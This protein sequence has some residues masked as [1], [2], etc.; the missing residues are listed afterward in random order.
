MKFTRIVV[1]AAAAA[2]VVP[3]A[4]SA[5]SASPAGRSL[6]K[7]QQAAGRSGP[8][9]YYD[10]RVAHPMVT[11]SG[12][13]AD[14]H[15]TSNMAAAQR[16]MSHDLGLR[17]AYEVN[18]ATGTVRALQ[19][20]DGAL[21][22]ASTVKPV[23]RG[24]AYVRGHVAALGLSSSDLSAFHLADDLVTDRG[25]H[26]IRWTES[27]RGIPAFDNDLRVN[28]D[29]RGQVISVLGSPLH[30]LQLSSTRPGVSAS[31][32]MHALENNVRSQR[33]VAVTSGPRGIRQLTTFS[34]GDFARLVIFGGY[35]A[36]RL[37]WHLTLAASAAATYDAVVD[38]STGQVLYRANL[39]KSDSNAT[40]FKNYPGAIKG[41]V[42]HPVDLSTPTDG[43]PNGYL[44]PGAT[45]LVGPNAHAWSDV[46]DDDTAQPSEEVGPSSGTDFI[47]PFTDFNATATDGGCRARALCSW[48][49]DVNSDGSLQ[50]P[51]SWHTNRKQDAVQAFWY[52]NN[53]HDHLASNP[54]GFTNASGQNF[55]GDDPVLVNADDGAATGDDGGPD[56][57]HLDN[58]N[59]TTMP[60]GTS[61]K[62]QMYL[63]NSAFVPFRDINGG[64]AAV[65]VYHENTHG[66][67]NRLITNDDGTGAV[68]SPEA[69]AMG[70]AWSDWY[71]EDYVTR[72]GLQSDDP[73]HAGD[74]N[75]GEY[76]DA[77][78]GVI[79]TQALDCPVGLQGSSACPGRA[80]GAGGGYTFGD[81]GKIIGFPEVHAD[82]EIWGETLW[83][84]RTALIGATGDE[85]LGS[86]LAERMITD[87]MRL[88]PPEPTYLEERNAILAAIH[89]DFA[90]GLRDFLTNTA[91]TVFRN[92]GMGFYAGAVN[93]SDTTPVEDF[94]G[95]P[96]K[97]GPTGS[98]AG[99]VIDGDTGLPGAGLTV[100]I[101]GFTD[102]NSPAG[103]P[104][105]TT[106]DANGH[107]RIAHVPVGTY[108]DLFVL[109]GA[110]F[111]Q[112]RVRGV[113]VKDH[114]ETTADAQIHR[115][116]A[117]LSGGATATAP[118]ETGADFGCGSD[119]LIDQ[120]E[121]SGYSAF[122]PTS[123]SPDNPHTGA[124]QVTVTL[125]QTVNVTKFLADPGNTCGDGAS[126]TTHDF[127]IETSPNGTTWTT[128]VT[129]SFTEA[130]GHHLNPLSPVA[131]GSNVKYV[132]LTMLNPNDTCDVCSGKDFID[133]S[134]LEV[135]GAQPTS[136][137]TG[138]LDAQPS[139]V[140]RGD[141]V[142]FTAN[143]TDPGSAISSYTW[144]F[145]DGSANRTTT[146][147]TT[148]HVYN[149]LGHHTATVT[150]N[151]F[152][153]NTGQATADVTVDPPASPTVT[154]A[155]SGSHGG[156]PITVTCVSA[157]ELR[158][159]GKVSKHVARKDGL[160]SRFVGSLQAA[161]LQAGQATETLRLN[162]ETVRAMK[163]NHVK[164]LKVKVKARA[165]D[166]NH[167]TATVKQ[168][169]PILL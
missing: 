61:P 146:T 1:G 3:L 84:L 53:F 54:I 4:T 167:H 89:A 93:G 144:D 106:T 64:D 55:N 138:T 137:P 56:G 83:D 117:A 136:P 160:P 155:S 74:I 10:I 20:L 161:L 153:G 65:V 90:G 80:P 50:N 14:V 127:T 116:W 71:A 118:D 129:G 149:V 131:G 31:Q 28:V 108:N 151:A 38:A 147:P 110:G 51:T 115:D 112:A 168:K 25:L 94:S 97:S 75:L 105:S 32:A 128:A 159:S 39:T 77:V 73:N 164:H 48:D 158:A 9:P 91:W 35:G 124:P 165:T 33:P 52:V 68:G 113:S 62:M 72:Q 66:L 133:F 21:T 78:P 2:L 148:S 100:G 121:S 22:G 88:S 19:R 5:A 142:N 36:P 26:T 6:P 163:A 103:T 96:A 81:F 104:L 125:P 58:A 46:N 41:G 63:F 130:D 69:G 140:T 82:G 17:G 122:N 134:E 169:V 34:T 42:Q 44:D 150:A 11:R 47:Y 79:R 37:A 7:P 85:V 67:S 86:N 132:R 27:Y 109:A 157:C 87:G 30:G 24:W 156:V 139:T 114:H 59:M 60:V 49:G 70:E 15:T 101:G 98:I 29:R 141:T 45:T 145:G 23:S 111:D 76:T 143:F 13:Y 166:A 40:V 99:T 126:A 162:G 8:L 120:D 43:S 107:Y 92:R 152:I 102:P 95:P 123:D 135:I 119:Q 154:I 16:Q 57:N 12:R 18:P